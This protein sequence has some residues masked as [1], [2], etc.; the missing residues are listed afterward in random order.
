[1]PGPGRLSLSSFHARD[2]SLSCFCGCCF[3]FVY[4]AEHARGRE[5]GDRA[6]IPGLPGQDEVEAPP[7]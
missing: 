6:Q 5:K 1:M 3:V 4:A 2:Q 7:A